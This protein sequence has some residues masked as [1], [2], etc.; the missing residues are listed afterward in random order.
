MATTA[1]TF[2]F[3]QEFE[4]K[5]E[6]VT[7]GLPPEYSH[8]LQDKIPRQYAMA[9]I[10]YIISLNAEVNPSQNYRKDVIKCLAS[11]LV[12]VIRFSL[13]FCFK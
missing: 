12:R 4:R 2:E 1:T 8:L 5:L 13:I 10:D 3:G 7:A 6:I 9:V 11:F